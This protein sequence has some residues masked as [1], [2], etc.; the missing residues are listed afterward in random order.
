MAPQPQ[1][2]LVQRQA[3]AK[4]KARRA[5]MSS[6]PPALLRKP[7]TGLPV[8][9]ASNPNAVISG[10]QPINPAMPAPVSRD[11]PNRLSRQLF[12]SAMD[13]FSTAGENAKQT[14]DG[15]MVQGGTPEALAGVGKLAASAPMFLADWMQDTTGEEK[16]D[17]VGGLI[18]EGTGTGQIARLANAGEPV[19]GMPVPG[20]VQS[21]WAQPV[22]ADGTR[23]SYDPAVDQSGLVLG[24]MTAG[25][26]NSRTIG[27]AVKEA[28]S[29]V[30]MGAS[31]VVGAGGRM[32]R[33]AAGA[34]KK[35]PAAVAEAAP[36]APVSPPAP[37]SMPPVAEPTGNFLVR[38]LDRGIGGGIGGMMGSDGQAFAAGADGEGGPGGMNVGGTIAGAG[39]GA[40]AP[41]AA[42]HAGQRVVRSAGAAAAA[43]RGPSALADYN[44]RIAAR[45]AQQALRPGGVTGVEEGVNARQ[46]RFGDKPAAIADL[47]QDA[48]GTVTGLSRMPGAT[49]ESARLRGEGLIEERSG[50][51]SRDVEAATGLSTAS[52][53]GDIAR[54]AEEAQARATPEYNRLRSTYSSILSGRLDTLR[55]VPSVADSVR[56][57]EAY[58]AQRLTTKNQ[59]MGDFEFWDLVKRDLDNKEQALIDKGVGMDDLRIRNI[60]DARSE[61]VSEMDTLVPEYAAARQLGGEAPRI[62]EA[63][64]EGRT[65]LSGRFDANEVGA[66]IEQWNG[67][68]LTAAQ[69]GAIR[70]IL[71]KT[72]GAGAAIASLR[73][74]KARDIL[75][76]VFGADRAAELDR[77]LAADA[78]I[79]QNAGRMNPNVG[80]AT[81]Q[82]TLGSGGIGP[83]LAD[84]IR[85]VRSPVEAGLA[86][87]SRSGGYSRA[88]RDLMGEMLQA[89]PTPE[90]LT[91]IF[92]GRTGG[93]APQA[94]APA[95]PTPAAPTTALGRT[96]EPQAPATT[97]LG[98]T[99]DAP[100]IPGPSA[101]RNS[102]STTALGSIGGGTAGYNA[103]VDMDG[104]GEISEQERYASGAMGAALGAGGGMALGR[105]MR[106]GKPG[107]AAP[108]AGKVAGDDRLIRFGDEKSGEL[109]ALPMGSGNYM[110]VGVSVPQMQRQ[111]GTATALY[112][113]LIRKAAA[114]GG[115]LYSSE[116]LTPGGVAIYDRL[117]RKGYRVEQINTTAVKSPS[118]GMGS[119]DGQPIFRVTAPAQ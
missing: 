112:E 102:M 41:R 80:S 51:L 74:R 18:I 49:G 103:P 35:A 108:K 52:V 31:D 81:S 9:P 84:A 21:D 60:E 12:D 111:K 79:V 5:R 72:D 10:D 3:I 109:T 71:G 119:D 75:A 115:A 65:Y 13:D 23:E 116:V 90:N 2:S 62:R 25:A 36:A 68:P 30:T 88:Q 15:A 64:A 89:D 56:A 4:A 57:V 110:A 50:R 117:K 86:A 7:E 39:I 61:L 100:R 54:M 22:G 95:P 17:T 55:E 67:A 114:E 82:A 91:R 45:G 113:S 40:M 87:L 96:A 46:G 8:Q 26:G 38:N 59:G 53:A 32:I 105:A 78:T 85:T 29:N 107:A 58:K 94:P 63:F 83:A 76:R 70:T 28:A 101:D 11:N 14:P 66:M 77:R 106:G 93:T 48:V 19:L 44:E 92:R 20:G 118:G 98:T 27:G 1:L 24:A 73:S 99:G 104:D 16:A 42:L 97:G 6:G 37:F 33:N 69:S 43:R 47:S 34:M